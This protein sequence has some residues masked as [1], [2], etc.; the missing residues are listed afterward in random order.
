MTLSRK[1]YSL[2]AELQIRWD[3]MIWATGYLDIPT[4]PGEYR[5]RLAR[6][7]GDYHPHELLELVLRVPD[8]QLA[9]DEYRELL[10]LRNRVAELEAEEQ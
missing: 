7:Q 10:R 9:P 1:S 4:E 5:A 3:A 8:R 2:T 6:Q